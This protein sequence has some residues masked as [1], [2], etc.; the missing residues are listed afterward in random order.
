[1]RRISFFETDQAGGLT[2]VRYRLD[3]ER[4]F[5]KPSVVR[6]PFE[7]QGFQKLADGPADPVVNAGLVACPA[8]NQDQALEGVAHRLFLAPETGG[9]IFQH[10]VHRILCPIRI[11]GAEAR[12]RS[13]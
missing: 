12:S 8:L 11:R 7:R 4:G 10:I 9:Q 2:G 6:P 1:M 3:G 13:G 5:P